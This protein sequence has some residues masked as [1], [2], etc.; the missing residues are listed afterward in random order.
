MT[1]ATAAPPKRSKV[2]G[3]FRKLDGDRLEIY[4]RVERT[5]GIEDRK[6]RASGP[7]AEMFELVDWFEAKT[8][9]RVSAEW[10]RVRKGPRPIDGQTELL[11]DERSSDEG[12]VRDDG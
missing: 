3:W 10:R 7:E 12:Q 9:L 5:K 6:I 1:Q 4:L 8:G 11:M 2:E